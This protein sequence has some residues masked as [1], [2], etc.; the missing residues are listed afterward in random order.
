MII[1]SVDVMSL[2]RITA[3]IYG[4]FGLIAGLFLTLLSFAGAG[5]SEEV[6]REVAWMGPMFGLAVVLAL[7]VIY[8]VMGFIGGA[9]GGWVFNNVCRAMGGL[10]IQVEQA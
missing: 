3:A 1:K 10:A 4:I 2:A 7:P 6:G 9:I 5:L 8:F